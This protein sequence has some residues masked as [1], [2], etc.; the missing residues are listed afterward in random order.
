MKGN[1]DS[2]ARLME[3]YAAGEDQVFEAIYRELSPPLYRFCLRLATRRAEADDLFQETFFKLHR[4]RA[5]F[6][7]GSNPVHWSFAIARSLYVSRLRYWRRRPEHLGEAA[8]VAERDDIQIDAATTPESEATANDLIDV[9]T[10]E[11]A[12]MSEKNR[13]AYV[14]LKE[15]GLSAKDAAALLGTTTEVVKQRAHRAYEQLR[16]A[17]GEAGWGESSHV[18]R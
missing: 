6:S 9:V 1:S 7:A 2:L 8:D 14:L 15:E 10:L 4:A 18:A 16:Y 11:L 17:L 12:R 5:T 13:S 3:R